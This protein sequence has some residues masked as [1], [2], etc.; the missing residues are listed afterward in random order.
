MTGFHTRQR[1][2]K[3]NYPNKIQRI[4]ITGV[5]ILEFSDINSLNESGLNKGNTCN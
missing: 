1:L 2:Y 3:Q 5:Y 4:T